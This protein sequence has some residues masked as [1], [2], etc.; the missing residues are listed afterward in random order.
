MK[1]V[2]AIAA[3][4]GLGY[5]I[6]NY[7]SPFQTEVTDPYYVEIRFR[8]QAHDIQLVGVGKMNSYEDCVARALTVWAKS[9]EHMGKVRISSECKKD[10]PQRY[11]KLFEN[12]KSHATYVAFDKGEG[13][14]RDARFLIY[15]VPASHVYKSC[16]EI[17]QKA[18]EKYSGEVYCIQ[19]TVG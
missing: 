11:L 7:H 10:L 1:L 13:G 19:G 8:Y 4:L 2:L 3:L 15:G 9:L 5:Y 18:K 12:K 6:Y 14:E 17:T 16:E